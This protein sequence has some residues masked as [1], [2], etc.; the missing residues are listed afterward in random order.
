MY[1]HEHRSL[2]FVKLR[3]AFVGRVLTTCDIVTSFVQAQ[4]FLGCRD[5]LNPMESIRAFP[6]ITGSLM[7]SCGIRCGIIYIVTIL[8]LLLSIIIINNIIINNIIIIIRIIII[9]YYYYYQYY[10]HYCYYYYYY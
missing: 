2:P 9:N 3:L 4:W 8:L 10:Y 7:I 6:E 5:Q 1:F